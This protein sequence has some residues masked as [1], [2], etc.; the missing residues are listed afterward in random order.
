MLANKR[1]EINC[2][3]RVRQ[4][5]AR[6]S[7]KSRHEYFLGIFCLWPNHTILTLKCI[8]KQSYFFVS[9]VIL[10]P[11]HHWMWLL[12]RVVSLSQNLLPLIQRI[13][14]IHIILLN[15]LDKKAWHL[16]KMTWKTTLKTWSWWVVSFILTKY[17]IFSSKM[18]LSFRIALYLCP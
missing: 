11:L 9:V 6:I 3:S 15:Q 1:C 8:W 12:G 7:I 10:L 4:K 5:V 14:T 2:Q 16:W 13:N 17:H 18:R